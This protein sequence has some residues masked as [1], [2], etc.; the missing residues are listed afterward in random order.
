MTN[1]ST[2]SRIYQRILEAITM[3]LMLSLAIVVVVGVIYRWA[4]HSLVWYDEVAAIQLCWLTYYGAALGA[5][6]RSH[7][8][9]PSIIVA[10][11][12]PYRVPFVIFGEVVVI[13][14]FAALAYLGVAVLDALRDDTLVSLTWVQ[15][16]F[17]QSVIPIGAVLYL[18]AEL[19]NLPQIWREAT[20]QVEMKIKH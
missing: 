13:G 5:L 3:T 16:K 10:V 17:T 1:L 18:I 6:K 20:G 19:L 4:G 14:F 2:I 15:L 7:I 8:G 11:K 9:I 12:P